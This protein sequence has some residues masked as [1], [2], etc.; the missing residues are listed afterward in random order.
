MLHRECVERA[1]D[2]LGLRLRVVHLLELGHAVVVLDAG[3]FHLRHLVALQLVELPPQ[4][5][6]GVLED[7]LDE[8]EEIE[9]VGRVRRRE[10]LRGV[11][12]V[13][14][15]RVMDREVLAEVGV[16]DDLAP[17]LVVE[18]D[19]EDVRLLQGLEHLEGGAA[20]RALVRV[21]LVRR[22][23]EMRERHAPAVFFAREDA[24][25]HAVGHGEARDERL[26]Q[27]GD[28]P[29]ERGLVPVHVAPIRRLLADDLALLAGV[30]P[31]LCLEL[32][33]LDDVLGR[34]GDHAALVIVALATGASAD[35]LEVADAEDGGL[36]AVELAELR[37]EHGADRHVDADAQRVG[38]ADDLEQA[39]LRELLHDEPVLGEQTGV[40]DADAVADEALELLA[41]RAVEARAHQRLVDAL[42][43]LLR[44][45]IHAHEVLRFFGAGALREV[46]EVDG[47]LALVDELVDRL[48]ERRLG[49]REVERHGAMRRAHDGGALSVERLE[50]LLERLG[51]AERR[52]HE[53]KARVR[54]REQ[55]DLPGDAALAVGVVVEL[56]EHREVDVGARTLGERQVREHLGGRADDR[57]VAI[58]RGV[59][60]HEADVVGAERA[61]QREELLVGERLDGARVERALASHERVEVRGLRHERLAGAG[62]SVEDHVRAFEQLEDRLLLRGVELELPLGHGRQERVQDLAA[63]SVTR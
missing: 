50:V 48:V 40:V 7:G 28:E 57:R 25:H 36:L 20:Q 15:E 5:D 43:L 26:G 10:Q 30:A 62:R 14:R 58:D 56:V 47:V 19:V 18:R 35:L 24:H 54:Q 22:L 9:L 45:V 13:E 37:E 11:E 61:D 44:A 29:I 53:E 52:A 1:V 3:A 2:E 4:D 55:R 17:P 39:L 59:A 33:V 12:Q 8:R 63:R 49:V 41:V 6:V 34:L 32:Q 23:D 51:I 16:D 21:A 31:G 42:L 38:A 60:G 27:R 46:D